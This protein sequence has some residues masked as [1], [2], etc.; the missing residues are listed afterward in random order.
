MTTRIV[1]KS[2]VALLALGST[3]PATAQMTG[4]RLGR[5]AGIEDG[6][7]VL[8]IMVDC[9][10]SRSPQYVAEI[11]QS[12]PGSKREHDLI[13]SNEGDLGFCMNDRANRLVLP[14]NVELTMSARQFRI[15]L[16]KALAKRELR[17]KNPE[18]LRKA[19]S[20]VLSIYDNKGAPTD[21]KQDHTFLALY[22]FGDCVL[23]AN[24][25]D[26]A[27]L[28]LWEPETSQYRAA[29]QGIIPSLGPCVPAGAEFKITPQTLSVALAEP[30]YHRL[31]RSEMGSTEEQQA[32]N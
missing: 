30:I 6:Q 21:V 3:I 7:A 8:D 2:V 4:S 22:Y 25:S 11:M 29:W 23:G 27:A 14:S 20:W 10:A 19:P 5:N 16:S 24:P 1:L 9:A 18:I 17:G 13:F 31:T 26:S 12:M 32:E 28:I 15:G